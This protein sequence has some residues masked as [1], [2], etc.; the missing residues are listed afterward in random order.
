MAH[1]GDEKIMRMRRSLLAVMALFPF[2]SMCAMAQSLPRQPI[3]LPFEAAK[4]GSVLTFDFEAAE[5][6][7]YTFILIL[8]WSEN[9][10]AENARIA[11]FMG[12]GKYDPKTHKRLNN[13]LPIPLRLK[14]SRL[15]PAG[16]ISIFD[17]E[18]TEEELSGYS[19]KEFTK[20]IDRIELSRG[21]YR[22]RVEA[23]RDIPELAVSPIK[24][25]VFIRRL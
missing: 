23:L 14:I 10:K 5:N 17:K 3:F 24:C 22:V 16:D 11:K 4:K 20:I 21:D 9:D 25:G 8:Q 6:N 2:L 15:D 1:I 19:T 12:D 18:I 7:L 13:G